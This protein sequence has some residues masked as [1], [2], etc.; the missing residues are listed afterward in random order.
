MTKPSGFTLIELLVTI[1]VSGILLA[2]AVPS[3]KSSLLNSARDSRTQEFIEA[4]VFAR[5]KAVAL[6][7]SVVMCA[8]DNPTAAIP[9][10]NG[11][12][13]WESGWITFIDRNGSEKLEKEDADS[14]NDNAVDTLDADLN[15]DG[16]LRDASDAIIQRRGRLISA[17]EARLPLDKR[18]TLRGN[19]NVKEKIVFR[20]GGITYT[21][22]SFAA[23]DSRGEFLKYARVVSIGTG[24]R[25]RALGPNLSNEKKSDVPISDCLRS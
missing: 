24:G 18:F 6:R 19:S 4:L 16:K 5:S 8:S 2:I 13:G 22:G 1:T 25:V 23:C 21:I 7:R 11:S 9:V 12:K 10:C 14:N 15:G 17:A 3:F 20:A